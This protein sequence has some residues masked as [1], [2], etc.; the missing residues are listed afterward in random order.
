MNIW[1]TDEHYVKVSVFGV[2][3]I[4]IFPHSDQKNPEYGHVSHSGRIA[5]IFSIVASAPAV[6]Y[7]LQCICN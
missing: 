6:V 7:L 3:L 4:R 1:T 2:F 5:Y